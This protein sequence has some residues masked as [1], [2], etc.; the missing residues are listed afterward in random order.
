VSSSMADATTSVSEPSA[1][2][3]SAVSS[4]TDATTSP[5]P[6]SGAAPVAG[7]NSTVYL[8]LLAFIFFGVA[9]T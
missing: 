6:A 4:I 5:T 8:L 2:S 3:T 9:R 7:L 1:A